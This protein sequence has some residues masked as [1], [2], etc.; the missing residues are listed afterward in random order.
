MIA[1]SYEV[2]LCGVVYGLKLLCLM[3]VD[4]IDILVSVLAINQ[5]TIGNMYQH[6]CDYELSLPK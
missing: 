1:T 2:N 5:F 6:L 4:T 3:C